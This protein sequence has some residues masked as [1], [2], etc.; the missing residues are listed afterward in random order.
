MKLGDSVDELRVEEVQN[1]SFGYLHIT[2]VAAIKYRS[3]EVEDAVVP[4]DGSSPGVEVIA[5]DLDYRVPD[6]TISRKSYLFSRGRLGARIRL[7]RHP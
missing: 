6:L 2:E 5:D 3:A 7:I 4:K 1:A